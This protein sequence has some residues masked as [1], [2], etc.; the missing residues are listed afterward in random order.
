SAAYVVCSRRVRDALCRGCQALA[1]QPRR[2]GGGNRDGEEE[3]QEEGQEGQEEVASRRPDP[4]RLLRIRSRHGG[5]MI[6][7]VFVRRLR[8]GKTYDDF[9]AAWY[10]DEGFGVPAR[11][12][13]GA[14]L[15]DPRT[16]VTVG[17]VDAD[18]ADLEDLGA[19]I[20]A[21]EATRHD[22]IDAV[23]ES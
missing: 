3:E 7:V 18:P 1:T 21:N 16:I 13:A 10:P 8:E 20:S 11:V 15:D 2:A 14:T 22:R 19:R 6:G 9:R 12:L 23:I 17:F 4:G 5:G